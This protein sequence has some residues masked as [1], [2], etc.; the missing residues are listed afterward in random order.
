MIW[1][2]KGN[3]EIECDWCGEKLSVPPWKIKRNKNHF[4]K[5]KCK[6][7][8]L[9][10]SDIFKKKISDGIK[11]AFETNP[12]LGFKK[13]HISSSKGKKLGSYSEKRIKNISEGRRGIPSWSKGLTKESNP[14][15]ARMSESNK[16]PK[17]VKEIEV[18]SDGSVKEWK[19]TKEVRHSEKRIL[20]GRKAAMAW[21]QKY[22]DRVDGIMFNTKPEIEM[23][24][25]LEELGIHYIHQYPIRS[26]KHMYHADFFL[27]LYNVILEVDGKDWHNY[28]DGTEKDAIRTKE[29]EDK[30]FRVIRFWEHEFDAQKVWKEL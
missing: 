25:C 16:H 11:K 20:A 8:F 24:R 22:R 23:K 28:P 18:L 10:N 4:C 6:N 15:I 17:K 5:I 21:A 19:M 7:E 27:P 29:L 1:N 12:N 13:G 26:I 3:M 9:K 30:G 2:R 14:V